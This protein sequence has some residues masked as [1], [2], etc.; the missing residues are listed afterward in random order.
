LRVVDTNVLLYSVNSS[1]PFHEQAVGWLD[2]ALSG[3]ASVGLPWMSLLGFIRI[4]T[5][6]DVFTR[7]LSVDEALDAVDDWLTSPAAHVL[8][9]G[10]RH[11]AILRTLLNGR[12]RAGTLPGDAHLAALAI[13]HRGVVVSFDSDF[14]RFPGVR[15]KR[16][17]I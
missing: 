17:S 6:P 15:W 4:S 14:E 11:P 3:K 5:R 2:T 1:S 8:H 10:E 7:P 12:G 9:P 13:E 16:P